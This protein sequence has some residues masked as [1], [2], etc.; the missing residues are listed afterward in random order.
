[1]H[2]LGERIR[3]IRKWR[4][5]SQG[6]LE[7]R[8]GIKREYLSKLETSEL[9]NPTYG[10]LLKI[11][12]ALSTP[13]TSLVS[14]IDQPLPHKEPVLKVISPKKHRT[15]V[16]RDTDTTYFALPIV[17]DDLAAANPLYLGSQDIEDYALV[18]TSW[19]RDKSNPNRYRCLRIGEN[20]RAMHPLLDG[21]SIICFDTHQCNPYKLQRQMGVLCTKDGKTIVR[22]INIGD[23]HL[24]A[25]P[26]NVHEYYLNIFPLDK[27]NP[28][29]G[30]V[31]WYLK[32]MKDAKL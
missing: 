12:S 24:V 30:K 11:S 31:V 2:N 23:G 17:S 18:P 10:T 7:S 21:G 14:A 28:I 8:S 20:N 27:E 25:I 22:H 5:L 1:M 19:V 29:I 26:T 32:Q 13:L 15:K 9:K 3:Q 6:E 4:G 16:A